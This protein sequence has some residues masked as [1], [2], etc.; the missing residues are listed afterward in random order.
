MSIELFGWRSDDRRACCSWRAASGLARRRTPRTYAPWLAIVAT[1]L[2][3]ACVGKAPEPTISFTRIPAAARGGPDL[4]DVIAGRVTNVKPGQRLVLYARNSVW[5]V[6]PTPNRPY[7]EIRDDATFTAQTHL[8]TEY[9]ALLVEPD[10]QPPTTLQRLP[11]EGGLVAR[12][13]V[14]PGDPKAKAPRRTV[15]FAG[16]EWTVRAAPSDRGGPNR[17]DPSNAWTDDTGALH[18]RIAGAPGRWTCAE[19]TLTRSF[20]Y[21]RYTFTVDDLSALDPAARLAIFTWDGPAI[22]EYGREMSL[23]FGKYG[24]RD[25][26]AR[27]VV[28]PIDIPENRYTFAAPGGPLTHQ[29]RWEPGRAS[30]QTRVGTGGRTVAAH[31]FTS[32]VP[33][34]GNETIRFSLYVLHSSRTPMQ[35]PAEVVI[36]TFSFE[37]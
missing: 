34:A 29:L 15:Q 24:E 18:L 27:Y 19:V 33:G 16:Y 14:V 25:H 17:F 6:Q 11:P 4:L 32:G 30:F 23:T 36:R 26:N 12:L 8:G 28:E 31:S 10:Y 5:W 20:G 3:S 2:T 9:A 21:G 7:T 35:K 37:P 13:T 22:A 1:L